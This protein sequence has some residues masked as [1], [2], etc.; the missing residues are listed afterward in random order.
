MRKF[1]SF[2]VIGGL[3]TVTNLVMFA[4]IV[5]VF[6]GPALPAAILCYLVAATQN[7]FLNHFWTF[8]EVGSRR[9]GGLLA[10]WARFLA[11]SLVGLAIN[12]LVLKLCLG[13]F[14]YA[15]VAQFLGIVVA[16]GVN[17]YVAK[18]FVFVAR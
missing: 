15:T 9:G 11:G 4:L 14:P 8:R 7:Y 2:A 17:F 16:L 10:G 13:L 5:D 1:L 3:G 12:L 18:R 6:R